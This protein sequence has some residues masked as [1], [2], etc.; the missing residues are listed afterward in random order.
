LNLQATFEKNSQCAVQSILAAESLQRELLHFE[1]KIV[2]NARI[3]VSGAPAAVGAS[4]FLLCACA[5]LLLDHEKL[6]FFISFSLKR[7]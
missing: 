4:S 3:G 7:H 6:K 2:A 1:Q 5:S